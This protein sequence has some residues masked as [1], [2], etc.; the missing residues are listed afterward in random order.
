MCRNSISIP[1]AII[2]SKCAW[3]FSKM[4]QRY[5]SYLKFSELS[6]IFIIRFDFVFFVIFLPDIIMKK[7]HAKSKL[8]ISVEE[9]SNLIKLTHFITRIIGMVYSSYIYVNI[10]L[11]LF[12]A[13]LSIDY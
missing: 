10:V 8:G 5:F 2:F 6:T 13:E 12:L 4:I 11:R 3:L 9:N 1:C 7:K